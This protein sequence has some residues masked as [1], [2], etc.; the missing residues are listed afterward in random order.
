[1]AGKIEHIEDYS[2]YVSQ[3][4]LPKLCRILA[5]EAYGGM[6]GAHGRISVPGQRRGAGTADADAV[7]AEMGRRIEETMAAWFTGCADAEIPPGEWAAF[8]RGHCG[9]DYAPAARAAPIAAPAQTPK[10][11]PAAQGRVEVIQEPAP[12]LEADLNRAARQAAGEPAGAPVRNR[13]K[14]DSNGCR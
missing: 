4:C 5:R 14:E 9:I 3:R 7:Y 10:E 13:S 1:M 11:H 6:D 12:D 2:G 8:I